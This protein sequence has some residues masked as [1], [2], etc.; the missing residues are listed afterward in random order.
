VLVVLVLSRDTERPRGRRPAPTPAAPVRTPAATPTT[1]QPPAARVITFGAV[2]VE[3]PRGWQ[4]RGAGPR[5]LVLAGP[6]AARVT[7][8]AAPLRGRTLHQLGLD[9]RA[10]L[11]PAHRVPLRRVSQGGRPALRVTAH[12]REV[13]ALVLGPQVWLIDRHLGRGGRGVARSVRIG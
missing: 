8:S 7:V 10:A 12:G 2:K 11:T 3:L 1:P 9:T 5:R 13:T 6:G 4:A